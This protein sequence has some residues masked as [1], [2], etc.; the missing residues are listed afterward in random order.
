M[1]GGTAV[2]CAMQCELD[3]VKG[4]GFENC[5]LSGM[6]KVNAAIAATKLIE[7]C[8][9]DRILSIGV[10]GSLCPALKE[11]SLVIASA[12]AYHDVF[13]GF[14]TEPGQVQGYPRFFESDAAMLAAAREALPEATVGLLICG[15]QFF[16]SLDDD[17][18]QK[19]LYPDALAVDMET[20]AI[21]QTCYKA[22]V[23]FLAVRIVS[24]THNV[25][26][27]A[28]Y[29]GFWENQAPAAFEAIRPLLERW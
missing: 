16:V 5:V 25:D 21:A 22:G 15:D 24:D 1:N 29:D 28:S 20:A 17:A 7:N 19:A 23:P 26:Q 14:G 27:Q 4:L 8:R 10:S 12:C 2:I 18:R 6:G 11:C 3:L 13:Y 9:P